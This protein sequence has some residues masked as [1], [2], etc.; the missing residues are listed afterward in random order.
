MTPNADDPRRWWGELRA[1]CQDAPVR[2]QAQDAAARIP[3]R[4]APQPLGELLAMLAVA[5]LHEREAAATYAADHLLRWPRHHVALWPP[6]WREA[7]TPTLATLLL[8]PHTPAPEVHDAQALATL[9]KRLEPLPL[10]DLPHAPEPQTAAL[11]ALHELEAQTWDRPLTPPEH[12]RWL[13]LCDEASWSYLFLR[14]HV[15][16]VLPLLPR[17]LELMRLRLTPWRRGWQVIHDASL[18]ADRGG[19]TLAEDPALRDLLWSCWLDTLNTPPTPQPRDLLPA[20]AEQLAWISQTLQHQRRAYAAFL[21]TWTPAPHHAHPQA[22]LARWVRAEVL[23][24]PSHDTP[25]HALIE[26]RRAPDNPARRPYRLGHLHLLDT[27]DWITRPHLTAALE[28]ATPTTPE[29]ADTFAQAT[30]RL[31]CHLSC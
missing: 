16:L 26:E 19:P 3:N 14:E 1:L 15:R 17:L 20:S 24:A 7:D 18:A 9:R 21:A 6:H 29:D 13:A 4:A 22:R 2:L 10:H 23:V 12:T 31:R 28:R 27:R 30:A 25:P 8:D 11:L 5:P